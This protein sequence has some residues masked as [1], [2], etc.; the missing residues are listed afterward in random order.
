MGKVKTNIAFKSFSNKIDGLVYYDRDDN[1]CVRMPGR[2][3]DPNTPKQ[4]KVR[5]AM[6]RN[7]DIWKQL[8]AIIIEAWKSHGRR[9]RLSNF[10]RFVGENGARQRLGEPLNLCLEY[11]VEPFLSFAARTGNAAGE[12][13]CEFALGEMEAVPYVTFFAHKRERGFGSGE[14]V[15]FEAGVGAVSPY[16]MTSLE[17]G[18]E[19][20]IYALLTDAPLA[21]ATA[22]SA[23][24]C[25]LAVAG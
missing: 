9:K 2:R 4:R 17:A 6:R 1:P 18:A 3:I 5:Q 25:A 7:I 16:T 19:Y 13:I 12:I 20:Y 22:V 8:D 21:E 24:S 15:R 11:G 14:L 10:A 23:T